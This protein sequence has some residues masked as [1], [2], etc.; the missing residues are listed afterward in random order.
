MPTYWSDRGE[1]VMD[2]EPPVWVWGGIP[3]ERAEVRTRKSGQHR[4]YVV[5]ER[6]EQPSPHR[7]EPPCDRFTSCGGCPWMHLDV[8][9][10]ADA[11]V[12]R[13]QEVFDAER[14]PVQVSPLVAS[15]DGLQDFRHVSKL[16]AGVSDQGNYRLGA[17]ARFSRRIVSIPECNVLTPELRAV[18]LAAAHAMIDLDV[19]P[20]HEGRGLLRYLQ[21]RQSRE[22]GKILLTIVAGYRAR[23]L[24]RFA[25]AIMAAVPQV[26][27]AHLHINERDDNNIFDRD[28]EGLVRTQVIFG[29][30]HLEE[31]VGDALVRV[32]PSDFFQTNPGVGEL[33]VQHVL[34]SAKLDKGVPVVDL[35]CGVGGTTLN[36]AKRTEWALG[37][38]VNSVAI[39]HARAAASSQVIPA[40][41]L[42]GS[43]DEVLESQHK[44]L[45]GMRPVVL[46]NPARRGLEE[47]VGQA[48]RGLNPRRLVY[49]SCSPRN[50]ARDLA[51]FVAEGWTVESVVPFDMFPN[52][53]HVEVV[54]TL[55]PADAGEGVTRRAP[56]RRTVKRR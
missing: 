16:L 22:T 15:P 20:F 32:G 56:R 48:I 28:E 51:G 1:A 52:T 29:D 55:V 8:I 47:G 4:Q 41:F 35:Y 36:A 39:Q 45:S 3:G 30:A 23:I 21:A 42:A 25:E 38:E 24:D 9:G 6:T 14:I 43:V 26:S 46:V 11:R 12:S 37:V 40:E 31:R 49:T 19:R 2:G 33:L 50:L 7:V 53:Q 17:P 13:V 54:A 27:G 5:F 34:D 44:R 18:T 10:Q